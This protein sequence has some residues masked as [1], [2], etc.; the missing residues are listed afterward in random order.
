[1]KP[2][3]PRPGGSL[4]GGSILNITEEYEM[5]KSLRV[6]CIYPGEINPFAQTRMSQEANDKFKNT[7]YVFI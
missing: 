7:S 3:Q 1:M 5:R 2:N 6:I 4:G